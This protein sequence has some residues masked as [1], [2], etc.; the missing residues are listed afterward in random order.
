MPPGLTSVKLGPYVL[1]SWLGMLPGILLY[2]AAGSYGRAA[3]DIDSVGGIPWSTIG[4]VG[5]GLGLSVLAAG[6]VTR[7]VQNTLAEAEAA[8]TIASP[9][10]KK[11]GGDV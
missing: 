6:Y 1:A 10:K 11:D 4:G 3:L 9:R 5:A 8:G 2:I 7:L